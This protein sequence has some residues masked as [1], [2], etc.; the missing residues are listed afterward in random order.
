[1][2][3]LPEMTNDP[4]WNEVFLAKYRSRPYWFCLLTSILLL[5]FCFIHWAALEGQAAMQ[6]AGEDT[7]A[8]P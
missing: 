1:M 7:E 3:R 6:V 8:Q 4:A 5:P 2:K